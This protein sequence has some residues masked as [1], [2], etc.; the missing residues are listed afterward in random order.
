MPPDGEFPVMNYRMTQEFKPPFHINTLI[1]E[2]G[3]LKVSML[4]IPLHFDHLVEFVVWLCK[5]FYGYCAFEG[6]NNH[7][8]LFYIEGKR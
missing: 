3:S 1:E 2:A 6:K 7:G 5:F 4:V 8:V